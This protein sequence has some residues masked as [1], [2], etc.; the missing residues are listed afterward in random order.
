MASIRIPA[1][2]AVALAICG[3]CLAYDVND[4]LSV[5]GTLALAGQCQE[6]SD[7]NADDKCKRALPFQPEVSFRPTEASE[8]FFKLGFADA[9]GLNRNSPFVLSPWAADLNDDVKDING[10]NRNYLLTAWYKHTLALGDRGSVGATVGIIDASD[11]LNENAYASDEYTQ[12]MNEALVS[13]P[14]FFVPS[15]DGGAALEWEA[16]PWSVR[17][18]YMNVGENGDGKRFDFFG[19]QLGYSLETA[20]GQGHYRLVI[21]ATSEDFLNPENT[22]EKRIL[23]LL[24]PWDQ[25]LGEVV[26]LFIR[27]GWQTDDAAVAYDAIYSGGL[28]IQGTPW[29][30][31][32]DNI[33]VG[34][35]YLSGGNLDIDMTHVAEAYYRLVLDDH[36]ALTADIQYMNDH[37]KEEDNPKGFILGLRATAQF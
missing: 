28:N 27:L 18:A 13:G 5:G 9:N 3:P 23:G 8:I 17:G 25:Q 35:A 16:G 21:S 14:G 29:G 1:A 34:Y 20:L 37:L 33:G 11:Y 2:G 32:E 19:T 26:G 31:R 24:L 12:F 30:R 4:K 22:R 36:L 10:R 15:Y 7:T 6:L